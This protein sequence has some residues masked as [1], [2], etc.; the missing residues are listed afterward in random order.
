MSTTTRQNGKLQLLIRFRTSNHKVIFYSSSGECHRNDTLRSGRVA[1][2]SGPLG[3]GMNR[4][5]GPFT[6][7]GTLGY[8]LKVQNVMVDH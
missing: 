7:Q 1:R 6:W 5:G 4:L 8:L 2:Y 3:Y